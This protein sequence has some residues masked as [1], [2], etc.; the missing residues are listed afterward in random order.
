MVRRSVD[1]MPDYSLSGFDLPTLAELAKVEAEA[2]ERN[3][4]AIC[5]EIDRDLVA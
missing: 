5:D 1:Q 3:A 2:S 4:E